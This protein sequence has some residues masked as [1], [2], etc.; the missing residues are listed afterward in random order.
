V[1][2]RICL[3][4][5]ARRNNKEKSLDHVSRLEDIRYPEH[6]FDYRT[7]GGRPGRPLKR[8]LDAVERAKQIN[9]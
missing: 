7:V 9:Y 6:L 5:V 1:G 2:P 3:D 8:L 4:A